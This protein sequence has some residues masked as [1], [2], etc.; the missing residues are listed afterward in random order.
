[1]WGIMRKIRIIGSIDEAS[2]KA[3]CEEM[4]KLEK[5][6]GAIEIE[7]SSGGGNAYDALAFAARIRNSP[8]HIRITAFGLV[9]S[10][11]VM[12]LAAADHRM[13]T[14][15][16]W[17]MVHEDSGRVKGQVTYLEREVEHMRR[18]EAQWCT[19]LAKRTAGT[20]ADYWGSIHKETTYLCAGECKD[21]GL[22]DEVV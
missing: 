11:A 9:A 21:L 18:M 22:I 13:M 3:F 10:A 4:D 7:L 5:H 20:S 8:C 16:G 6:S 14:R 17:V 15:E 2:F 1:M 19:L 12:I